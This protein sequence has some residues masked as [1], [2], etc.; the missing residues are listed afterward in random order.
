M[1]VK[2][3]V[4]V[5]TGRSTELMSARVTRAV[6]PRLVLAELDQLDP[7]VVPLMV[8]RKEDKAA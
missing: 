7:V 5:P 8:V 6:R 3:K 1:S 4:T 2:R